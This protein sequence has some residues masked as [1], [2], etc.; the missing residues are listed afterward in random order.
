MHPDGTR[1]AGRHNVDGR[2]LTI[3]PRRP[4]QLKA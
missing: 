1:T 2:A 4:P 3:V